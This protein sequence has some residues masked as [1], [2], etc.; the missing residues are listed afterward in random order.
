MKATHYELDLRNIARTLNFKRCFCRCEKVGM[1][2][3]N[4]RLIWVPFWQRVKATHYELD[5]RKIAGTLNFKRWCVFVGVKKW[6]WK[7]EITGW[8]GWK[9][10]YEV[11]L[12]DRSSI[13]DYGIE[14][15]SQWKRAW[16][17]LVGLK[18]TQFVWLV[19]LTVGWNFRKEYI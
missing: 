17:V 15:F 16:F 8:F 18:G 4:H 2:E 10:G 5:L 13:S 7:R 9:S 6:V 3:R 1:K 11:A 14:F 12:T 19:C